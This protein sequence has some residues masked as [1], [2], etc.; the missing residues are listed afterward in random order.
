MRK[1]LLLISSNSSGRGG[2]ERYLIY[3]T[4]GLQ[5]LNCDV[6]ILL[7]THSYMNGWASELATEGATVHRQELRSLRDRP[8]R[9]VQS[10][11]DRHQHQVVANLC[12][13]LAPDGILVNQQYDEDGLD[14]VAGALLS[15]TAPVAG[16]MHMPMTATKN[17]R[18]FGKLRGAIL[19]RW[20]EHHPYSLIFV[21]QGSK[22][23]FTN[24][25]D[26][27]YMISV[28]NYGCPF[29]KISLS[30]ASPLQL[31]QLDD[32]PV[33]GFIGQFVTQKNLH[34]LIESWLWLH[35]QGIKTRLL[36]VGDGPERNSIEQKLL[37]LAPQ[38]TWQITGWQDCPE[39]FLSSIDVYVMTS[40]FEGLPLALIEAVGSGVPAVVTNFNGALD[41]AKQ[42]SWVKVVDSTN[43][44]L[45]G[46]AIANTIQTLPILKQ[47]AYEGQEAFRRYFSVQRMAQET[48]VALGLC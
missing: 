20:Y 28:V 14:Y 32:A 24:Y 21:S 19:Q 1:R 15:K 37:K 2:G 26:L 38:E 12:S 10:I 36:L 47:Q 40:D 33:I 9:F 8:L 7:S 25:Y 13:K 43:P 17:Q 22:V 46:Q 45:V 44:V 39:Q 11:T 27:G 35:T 31:I 42:A 4:Q 48:L 6:H 23:E 3:L 30:Q 34:F 29:S 5:K 16:I 41:V 18:P